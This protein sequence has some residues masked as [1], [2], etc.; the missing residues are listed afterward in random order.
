MKIAWLT[1]A[2]APYREPLWRELT[3]AAEF[4]ASFVFREEEVRHWVWRDNPHYRSS[5]VGA[6]TVPLPGAVA[7][8]L[9]SPMAWLKP[10]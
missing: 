9:D 6:W 8:R 5:V 2:Q 7:R 3:A 10:G 4:E 1:D